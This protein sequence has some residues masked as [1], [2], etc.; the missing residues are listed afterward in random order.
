MNLN[1]VY[2]DIISQLNPIVLLDQNVSNS[3]KR[4]TYLQR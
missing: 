3:E 2:Q 4:D 1:Q